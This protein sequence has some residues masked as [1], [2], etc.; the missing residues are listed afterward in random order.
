MWNPK[1]E[2]NGVAWYLAI[3]NQIEA[4]IENGELNSGDKLPTHRG[5]ADL[6][7]VTVGTVTRGYAEAE[8]RGWIKAVGGSGTVVRQPRQPLSLFTHDTQTTNSKLIDLSLNVP[9]ANKAAPE[10]G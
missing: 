3:A 10:S 4:A 6:L 9:L 2:T 7:E 1:P 8:R 5:L